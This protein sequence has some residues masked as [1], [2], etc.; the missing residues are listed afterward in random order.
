MHTVTSTT[1]THNRRLVGIAAAV[2]IAASAGT[3]GIVTQSGNSSA[4]TAS[5]GLGSAAPSLYQG[6][7]PVHSK[8]LQVLGKPSV[9]VQP[10]PL[11]SKSL[12][13]R[14]Q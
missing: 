11:R 7:D 12:L 13:F 14:G 4:G 3:V 2:A 6:A 5:D 1:F 9:R 8:T 10:D